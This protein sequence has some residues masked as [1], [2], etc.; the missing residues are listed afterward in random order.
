ME[1]MYFDSDIILNVA[2][3]NFQALGTVAHEAKHI[4]SLYHRL[5]EYEASGTYEGHPGWVEEGTAEVAGEMS[6]RIAWAARGGPDPGEEIS[7]T[8][9]GDYQ[10]A[11]GNAFDAS[12]YSLALKMARAVNYLSSQ[13]NGLVV[14]PDDSGNNGSVYGSGWLFHRW[15][16]DAYGGAG[17]GPLADSAFFR[18]LTDPTSA[19][20][21]AGLTQ[22][23]GKSF[24]E[25]FEEFAVAVSLHATQAPAQRDFTTYELVSAAE[26]FC[27]PNPLGV[28]PWPVTTTG[29]L[30]DCD[31]NTSEAS[32]PSSTFRTAQFTGPIGATG[33]RIHEFVSNGTGTGMQLQLS[34]SRPGKILVMRLR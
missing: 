32:V 4:V 23:T 24:M 28:F 14:A 30:G 22:E 16:A 15:L 11:T 10:Q 12:N 13:P 8:D 19:A 27:S 29:T 25:L 7:R 1:V 34:M 33:M 17:N 18:V 20:G 2:D 5:L 6:A 21:K 9:F 3:D 26:I 31:S